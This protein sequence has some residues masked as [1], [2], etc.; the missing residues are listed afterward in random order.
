MTRTVE[1]L[2]PGRLHFGLASFGGEGRQFGGLGMMVDGAGITLRVSPADCFHATGPLRE[3]VENFAQAFAKHRQLPSAPTC[4]VEVLAAPPDHTGLGVGTQLGLAVAAGLSEWLGTA[5]RDA[6]QLSQLSGRGQRSSIGTHG[7]LAGGLLVDAGKLPNEPL[8]QLAA[9]IAMPI[10]WRVVLI[11]QPAVHGLAG[12]VET[13]ALDSLPPVPL[14]VTQQ[15]QQLINE[16]ILPA[17]RDANWQSFS[18]ALYAYGHQAGKCF[19]AA[20]GGPF[21]SPEIAALVN[22]IRELGYPGAGQS[23]WGPTVFAIAPNTPAAETLVNQLQNNPTYSQHHFFI[24]PPNNTGATILSSE[25]V[26]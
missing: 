7:F 12:S 23:S 6:N 13:A 15:L 17:A 19:A 1:V 24:A 5:W 25:R 4:H 2:T 20:Q 26:K 14:V 21:A 11:R 22:H 9:R 16:K 18:E 8:G 3:R 10:T